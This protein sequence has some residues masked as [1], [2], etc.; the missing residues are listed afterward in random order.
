M[1]ITVVPK[2]TRSF[3]PV[4]IEIT[5]KEDLDLFKAMLAAVKEDYQDHCDMAGDILD[6]LNDVN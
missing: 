2:E 1:A 5:N 3:N 6:A 4:S